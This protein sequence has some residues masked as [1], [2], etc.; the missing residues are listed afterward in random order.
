MIYVNI[1]MIICQVLIE[2]RPV[3]YVQAEVSCIAILQV[4]EHHKVGKKEKSLETVSHLNLRFRTQF[5]VELHVIKS[6]W[7]VFAGMMILADLPA[8]NGT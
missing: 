5:S 8:V 7:K 2:D 1:S 3:N 4:L 6:T